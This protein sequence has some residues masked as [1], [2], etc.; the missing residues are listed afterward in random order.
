MRRMF[1]LS[2]LALG[3]LAAAAVATLIRCVTP[4]PS[5]PPSRTSVASEGALR[6]QAMLERVY[7][8][9]DRSTSAYLE[10]DLSAAADPAAR[11]RVPVN[12]VLILDRSGSMRGV[13]IERAREAARSLVEVLGPQDRIAIVEFSSDASVL[14]S[15]TAVSADARDRALAAVE[16]L[17][18]GGG[19]NMAKAFDA[20]APELARG[21]AHGRVD[22]VFLASDGQANEGIADRAG[23]LALARRD[24]GS[25]TLSTFGI[26]NDYDEDLM[27]ALAAQAGGRARY[28]DSPRMLAAAFRDELSRAAALVARGVRVRVTG[29]QGVSLE[30]VLGYEPDA[31]GWVRVPDFAAGEERRVLA[32]LT[33]PPGR[34]L[35]S[36]AA[37]EV[38]FED[39]GG[40]PRAAKALAQATFT[41]DAS[42]L[43][44]A[45]TSAAV[46]GARAEMAELAGQAARLQEDGR[47]AEAKA[48]ID[49]M[50]R[51]AQA[52]AR[53]VPAS[54]PEVARVAGEYETG[55][56][57]IDARGDA[58][59]KKLKENLFDV[60][61]APVAGW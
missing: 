49:A 44:T 59:S 2:A 5:P 48:R 34:G 9:Q 47:R 4:K 32:R 41:S 13:K 3:S 33:I 56:S 27:S 19:T 28:I 35:A 1:V 11:P 16:A 24:F 26:G 39:V 31:E 23:L 42:L 12:A 8:P 50:G 30:R 36:V 29:L 21:R 51:I 57:H 25:A 7:L 55:I 15:S 14:V 45:P 6:M 53:S 60:Q 17:E 20:G 18:V 40:S 54:A 46:A 38:A 52:A 58:A 43:A 22:K 37:V 61:R 10:V